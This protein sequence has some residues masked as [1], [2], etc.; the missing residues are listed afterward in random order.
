MESSIASK[1]KSKEHLQNLQ[2][3][4]RGP[5][6]VA[7]CRSGVP[8]ARKILPA[9]QSKEQQETKGQPNPSNSRMMRLTPT[10]ETHFA[11]T[12]I[13]TEIDES[14]RGC[15]VFVIQDVANSTNDYSVD[16]N[17]RAL[18]T[19]VRAAL[20]S[21]AV[22]VT[23]VLPTFP[24]ARQHRARGRE[25]VTAADISREIERLG[26][27]AVITLDIHK[28]E[29]LG[30]FDLTVAENLHASKNIIDFC[31]EAFRTG[32]INRSRLVVSSV[33]EGGVDRAD[34]YAQ[35]LQT[36]LVVCYK[37]R[38]YSRPNAVKSLR[39]LGDV[40]DRDVLIVDD[41]IDTGGSVKKVCEALKQKGA[42]NI[43]FACSLPLFNGEAIDILNKLHE[44]GELSLVIGTNAVYHGDNFAKTHK[45]FKEVDVSRYFAS[46]I[47]RLNRNM[48]VSALLE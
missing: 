3:L 16:E 14:I 5:L 21:G 41:M 37:Y 23:A 29:T 35:R 24:Y 20:K 9:L 32:V 17:I 30:V 6:V 27:H 22:H 4:P 10:I 31:K 40:K 11:N 34:H 18:K 45:W 46:V 25:T 44:R 38:D 48:S 2:K 36:E 1:G 15:D 7:A 43:Y 47:Y 39:V 12:E 33:D 42:R 13:K 26:T 19:T 28:E 8:F